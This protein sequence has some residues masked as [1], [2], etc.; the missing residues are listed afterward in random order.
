MNKCKPLIK[1]SKQ[2]GIKMPI[3]FWKKNLKVALHLIH[4]NSFFKSYSSLIPDSHIILYRGCNINF[5]K[6]DELG[7]HFPIS[8]KKLWYQQKSKSVTSLEQNYLFIFAMRY[9]VWALYFAK[10]IAMFFTFNVWLCHF[11]WDTKV[12]KHRYKCYL[13]YF[14]KYTYKGLAVKYSYKLSF[15]SRDFE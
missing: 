9:P 1:A 2:K 14:C 6:T 8:W 15:I 10:V 4:S 11:Y 12:T 5:L 7:I 3:K 13:K